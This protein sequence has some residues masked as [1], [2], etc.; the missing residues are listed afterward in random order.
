MYRDSFQETGWT[1]F[2]RALSASFRLGRPFGV[3]VR[4]Y[5]IALLIMP[6]ILLRNVRGL[7]F[8]EGATYVVLTTLFL[9]VIIWS[10]EMGHI[11]AGRRYGIPTPLMTLGP[12]GGLAHM[13]ANAPSPRKEM[14]V[15]LAGPFVHLLWLVPVI[16]LSIFVDYGDLRP[17]GW[18]TDP[19]YDLIG[20]LLWLNGALLVFNLLPFWP[21]DGGRFLRAFL[22]QR[23]HPNRATL[24]ATRVGTIGAIIFIAGGIGLWIFRDDLYGPILTCIGIGNLMACKQERMAV[25]YSAGPY[26]QSDPL[27]PWQADPEA[28]KGGASYDWKPEG[29]S[30]QRRGEKTRQK[31]EKKAEKAAAAQASLDAEVD[32]ILAK[33]SEVGMAGLTRKEKDTLRQASDRRKK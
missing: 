25:Q 20:T 14:V 11:A 32:R 26:L 18:W 16:P 10:H 7:P 27:Q 22:A 4:V 2:L 31:L 23:M 19:G 28:W 3:E 1:R 17:A 13:S 24:A 12:L 6:L 33:V 29:K 5:W 30:A 15:A 21:M 9:Y 8:I